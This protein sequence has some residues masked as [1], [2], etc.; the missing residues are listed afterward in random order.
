VCP[1]LLDIKNVKTG[2]ARI[3]RLKFV[4]DVSV[5]LV[6]Q[7]WIRLLDDSMYPGSGCLDQ[8]LDWVSGDEFLLSW[9][10]LMIDT[11]NDVEEILATEEDNRL[12]YNATTITLP[13][14]S[15]N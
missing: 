3:I 13:F 12:A 2:V 6:A 10:N 8:C 9:R 5:G 1:T 7:D 11:S 4:K 14:E 15:Q